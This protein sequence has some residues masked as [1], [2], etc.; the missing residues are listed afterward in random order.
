[1]PVVKLAGEPGQ[2][3]AGLAQIAGEGILAC[4]AALPGVGHSAVGAVSDIGQRELRAG[5]PLE[6]RHRP[7]CG[8]NRYWGSSR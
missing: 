6:C 7:V 8:S 5:R 1:M 3:R 2:Q 4:E